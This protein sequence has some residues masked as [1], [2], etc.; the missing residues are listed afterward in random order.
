MCCVLRFDGRPCVATREVP[1]RYLLKWLKLYYRRPHE[2]CGNEM[3]RL[4][5]P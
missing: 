1:M 5:Y 3:C 2:Y 4:C